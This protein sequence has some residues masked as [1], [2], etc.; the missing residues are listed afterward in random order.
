MLV[1]QKRFAF[2]NYKSDNSYHS[3]GAEYLPDSYDLSDT[4][5]KLFSRCH[6]LLFAGLS[7][8]FFHNPTLP[9]ILDVLSLNH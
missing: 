8:R 3:N 4:S 2:L 6:A 5:K 9:P 7:L 1:P